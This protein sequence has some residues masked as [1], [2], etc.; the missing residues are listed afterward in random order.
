GI[1][2][3]DGTTCDDGDACTQ[4]DRCEAEACR[5]TAPVIC[6][7]QDQC[8]EPGTC[9]HT[10]GMCSNPVAGDGTT[11]DDGDACTRTDTCQSGLCTGANPVIC[12]VSDQCHDAG[13][14]DPTT[15][16]CSNPSVS[17]GTACSDGNACT[18]TDT[19]Q[20]GTCT[21]SN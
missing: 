2:A 18:R 13:K 14:C 8:H 19:C 7:A 12:A 15:G 3:S 11:C 5:G 1:T 6:A 17:D 9:D 16:V 10:T 20:S 4:T 21:G